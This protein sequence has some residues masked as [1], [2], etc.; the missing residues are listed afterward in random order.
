MPR[1]SEMALSPWRSLSADE[2]ERAV[3]VS[4]NLITRLDYVTDWR[5]Q[6]AYY[7]AEV[8]SIEERLSRL[9]RVDFALWTYGPWSLHVREAVELLEERGALKRS[10]QP[11]RR[12]P[13]A[14]FFGLTKVKGLPAL[15]SDDEDFLDQVSKEIKYLSGDALTRAAKA[16]TPCRKAE[17][18]QL[19]DLDGYLEALRGKHAR[20]VRS[21]KV[22]ALVAEAKAE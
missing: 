1:S 17:A 8:R 5:L 21:P 9:S 4:A 12:R 20:F 2:A 22:A 3:A 10:R 18:G 19:I 11:A 15:R 14:E 7:L 6:K 16:T 13:E